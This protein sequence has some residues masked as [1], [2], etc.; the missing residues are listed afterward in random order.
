[1]KDQLFFFFLQFLSRCWAK[2]GTVH[3]IMGQGPMAIY[4]RIPTYVGSS[5]TLTQDYEE[6]KQSLVQQVGLLTDTWRTRP[7]PIDG[8]RE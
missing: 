4:Y 5:L 7:S 6:F 8:S 3:L 2:D 1:M